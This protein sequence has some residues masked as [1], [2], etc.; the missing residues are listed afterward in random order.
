MS[1]TLRTCQPSSSS[2]K[3]LLHSTPRL[4]L[5]PK[6]YNP[7][8]FKSHLKKAPGLPAPLPQIF[9]QKVLLSDGS[10]FTSYT[11]APTPEIIRLTRDV[12]NNALWQP[13]MSTGGLKEEDG[14]VGRFRRMFEGMDTLAGKPAGE[15]EGEG[16]GAEEG[17]EGVAKKESKAEPAVVDLSWMS[18][19][20][21]EER[22]P[23]PKDK[24]SSK[25]RR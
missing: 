8:A 1:Q 17:G 16:E 5:E 14:R 18:V 9:P 3:R 2:S 20:G 10:T 6:H 12:T 7:W 11:T 15:G 19:G 24:K 21:R 25:K 23:R 22:A 13:G 4:S